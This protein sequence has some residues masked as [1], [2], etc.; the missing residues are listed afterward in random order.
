MKTVE[1]VIPK[2][3]FEKKQNLITLPAHRAC[4]NGFAQ[5]DE[6]F[7]LCMTMAAAP[8]DETAKKIWEGPVMRGFHRPEMPGLKV[9]TLNSLKPIEIRTPA[10]L[11]LGRQEA[12]FQDAPRIQKVVSRIARGLYAHQIGKVLPLDW[13]V[14]SDLINH[15]TAMPMFS[16]FNCR[17]KPVGNGEFHFD[18]KYLEGDDLEGLFCSGRDLRSLERNG[19]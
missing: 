7:R 17:L 5:D 4:N 14:T 2:G 18:W 1:H 11:Y 9:S 12:M 8:K 10:G 15:N 19:A 3:L 13:P 6:Y 16:L